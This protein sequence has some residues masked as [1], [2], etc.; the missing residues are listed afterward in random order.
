M[1][2]QAG[3]RTIT[4]Y[5]TKKTWFAGEFRYHYPPVT[6]SVIARMRGWSRQILGV[7]ITPGTLW[8]MTPWTWLLDWFANIGDILSNISAIS[9]DNL[10]MRYGYLMQEA[11]RKLVHTHYGVTTPYGS[12]PPTFSGTAIYT[13]KTRMGASPYGFGLKWTEL[14]PRQLAILTAIG[15]TRRGRQ[16]EGGD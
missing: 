15:I 8:D 4:Q 11:T 16:F 7:D 2:Q 5:D 13:G 3:G 14:S 9:Q 1:I 6:A 12:I 10:A